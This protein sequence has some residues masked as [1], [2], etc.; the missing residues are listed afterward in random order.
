MT[1]VQKLSIAIAS[2][3]GLAG[4]L[5]VMQPA[6]KTGFTPSATGSTYAQSGKTAGET[7]ATC[8]R[9]NT[10]T[11]T[12]Q[13]GVLV[14]DGQLAILNSAHY[15]DAANVSCVCPT[16]LLPAGTKPE[17]L[18]GRLIEATG[19]QT[20]YKGKQQWSATSIVVK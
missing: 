7:L 18:K 12:C 17:M 16:S 10:F 8:V 20:E 5:Y 2:I 19:S 4:A 13:G 6:S 11:F 1:A 15:K 3:I 9:G 14:K